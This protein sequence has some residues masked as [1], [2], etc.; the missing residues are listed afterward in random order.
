MDKAQY[1]KLLPLVNDRD[2]MNLLHDYA[3]SRIE[4]LRDLLEK[5][6]DPQRILEVQ[7]AITELRRFKTLRDEVIKGAE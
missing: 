2:Q 7:G 3:A 4:G 5:Q 6:K 1:R